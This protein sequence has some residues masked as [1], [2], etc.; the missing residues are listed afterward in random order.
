MVVDLAPGRKLLVDHFVRRDSELAVRD[1]AG[2]CLT[3]DHQSGRVLF[4]LDRDLRGEA[5]PC[6][7]GAETLGEIGLG[8]Q[9]KVSR[10]SAVDR[11][12]SDDAAFRRKEKRLAR[13][14]RPE[15]LD[16]VRQHS[17]EIRRRVGPDHAHESAW[18][19][20]DACSRAWHR[21]SV[22]A[23]FRGRAERKV[24]DAGYDPARLPPGQYLT[25]KWPVLHAGSIP[26]TDLATWDFFVEG[27]VENPLRL[28][29]DELNALPRTTHTQ[30]IHCV[31]RWSRFDVTFEG[32]HWSAI[33]PLVRPLPSAHYVVA[34]AEEGYTANVRIAFLRDP[35]SLIATHAD[36]EPLTPEH[37][38]PLRLVIPGK[39]FWK[40]AKWLRGIELRA[41]DEPA[42]KQPFL[43][44]GLSP[45]MAGSLQT[46]IGD[47]GVF[48]ANVLTTLARSD[49]FKARVEVNRDIAWAPGWG[50][51]RSSKTAS[52][53]HWGDGPG[54]KN[55]CWVQPARKSALVFFT[56]GDSGAALYAWL[57][58]QLMN[59]DS[60]AFYWI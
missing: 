8:Q 4:E 54:F 12:R 11:H 50:V 1:A 7:R 55:F 23:V 25:E 2:G 48:L 19:L 41:T 21:T 26:T 20:A 29:W 16:V 53:F 27:E 46:T 59:E 45:N 37:G 34:H 14:V 10:S 9:Q 58:R 42:N 3:A 44:V 57:F 6:E 43:P 24:I 47:Y 38:G 31:T 32:V 49:D 13:L 52:L 5:T 35:L 33:E 30:D 28:S 18:S 51:D 39:Y 17:L 40:S 60:S 56:N 22:A 36:G 15:C